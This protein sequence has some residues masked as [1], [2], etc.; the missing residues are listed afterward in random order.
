MLPLDDARWKQLKH[1]YGTASDIPKFLRQLAT[2]PPDEGYQTEPYQPLWSALC[3]Q[4]DVYSASYAAV[5]YL[6]GMIERSPTTAPWSLLGLVTSI[7]VGRDR[8]N[9]PA[10]PDYLQKWYLDSLARI[11]AII[12]RIAVR[13]LDEPYTRV[14]S[15]AL[16]ACQGFRPLAAAILE[17]DPEIVHRV[18]NW[19]H[20]TES[21]E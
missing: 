5:P 18:I 6:L 14:C 21:D 16:A 11:P 2:V 15:A 4:G 10:I 17:L 9:A 12:S 20:G 3:H 1:A 13:P 7:E 19:I 8:E